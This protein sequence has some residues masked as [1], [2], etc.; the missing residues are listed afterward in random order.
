MAD[1]RGGWRW[2][3]SGS[4]AESVFP[5]ERRCAGEGGARREI[6]YPAPGG[7]TVRLRVRTQQV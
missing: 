2:Q 3:S 4:D 1:R 7:K 6:D 5:I